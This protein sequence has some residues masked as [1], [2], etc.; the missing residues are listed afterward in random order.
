MSFV[1]FQKFDAALEIR[2]INIPEINKF[3]FETEISTK[4]QE[5]RNS[6]KEKIGIGEIIECGEKKSFII[7]QIF[8]LTSDIFYHFLWCGYICKYKNILFTNNLNLRII[9]ISQR[10]PVLPL[11]LPSYLS[12]LFYRSSFIF[13][14]Y[15]YITMVN[16]IIH[17]TSA[18]ITFRFKLII[19]QLKYKSKK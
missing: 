17:P 4:L 15:H 8:V 13:N 12:D 6:V 5:I 16:I 3:N 1:W 2:E 7:P 19:L 10:F 18:I 11:P 14:S 9:L